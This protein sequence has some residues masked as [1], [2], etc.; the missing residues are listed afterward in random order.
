MILVCPACSTR[1]VVPD[2][3][4]TGDGRQVRCANCKHNWHQSPVVAAAAPAPEVAA[5]KSAPVPAQTPSPE[6][7]TETATQAPEQ[8]GFSGFDKAV[9]EAN[10]PKSE[11]GGAAVTPA[12]ESPAAPSFDETAIPVVPIGS[13]PEQ[14]QFAHEPPFK[15]RRNPAKLWTMAAAAFAGV[16]LLIGA[17]I[18]Y[19][20][21]PQ[22]SFGGANE[23]DLKIVL[24][25]NDLSEREDGTP[26]Y[27]AS[28]TIVNP[29]GTSQDVP[30]MLITLKD[31][32]GR[33][34][35]SWKL[36]PKERKLNAGSKLEFSE[37]RLDVPMASAKISASWVL[38]NN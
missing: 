8:Q 24:H 1:Y 29:T 7:A 14:S 15:P 25:N 10:T 23:P 6:P 13:E 12:A 16:V 17:A 9:E 33:P 27:I 37:A 31:A 5:P 21:V 20:G 18:W 28:G 19:F 11:D 30:D 38:E 35:Y 36:K 34:V 26:F 32:G 22:A 2:S 4:I 3:A